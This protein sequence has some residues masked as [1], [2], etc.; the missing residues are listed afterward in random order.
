[1]HTY[2]PVTQSDIERRAYAKFVKR[3]AEAGYVVHGF[4]L[5]DYEAAI[6]ESTYILTN[7]YE[8][9]ELRLSRLPF[10][11]W[12]WWDSLRWNQL[13]IRVLMN[14][15]FPLLHNDDMPGYGDQV[16]PNHMLDLLIHRGPMIFRYRSLTEE[17]YDELLSYRSM[18]ADVMKY[19]SSDLADRRAEAAM[20]LYGRN[21]H[22][23]YDIDYIWFGKPYEVE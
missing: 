14:D 17:E 18:V 23:I 20:A 11:N 8:E 9:A 19:A 5:A 22:P 4:D 13:V 12:S 15:Y 3:N 10:M 2:I 7:R 16:C 1:M 6:A 21:K